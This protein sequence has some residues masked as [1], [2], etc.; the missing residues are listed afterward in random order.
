MAEV[1]DSTTGNNFVIYSGDCVELSRQ[2]PTTASDTPY[3]RLVRVAL[4]L[5]GEQARHGQLPQ[6]CGF[7]STSRF[8]TKELYRITKPGRLLSFHCMLIPTSG[9]ATD[10][11]GCVTSVAISYERSLTLGSTS[12][13]R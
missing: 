11:S 13:A 7:S 8:L 9:R 6:R 10:S 1:M 2:L 4:H 5:L 3:S 12:I